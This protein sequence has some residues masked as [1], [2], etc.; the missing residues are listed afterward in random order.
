MRR[1]TRCMVCRTSKSCP[2][3]SPRTG[4]LGRACSTTSNEGPRSPNTWDSNPRECTW[5]S[6]SRNTRLIAR[7]KMI[8][9]F[10]SRCSWRRMAQRGQL[11]LQMCSTNRHLRVACW[12]LWQ[13]T[14]LTRIRVCT[15]STL[16]TNIRQVTFTEEAQLSRMI[17]LPQRQGIMGYITPPYSYEWSS[18][19]ST[20]LRTV[21]RCW[22]AT[23]RITMESLLIHT[24]QSCNRPA[25]L[26]FFA[27][28]PRLCYWW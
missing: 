18:W 10:R 4:T 1:A 24:I 9:R 27:V 19:Y 12:M 16:T 11:W 6:L 23:F 13:T 17:K 25:L 8:E 5:P 26:S 21:Q 28:Y 14:R 20:I 7:V 22:K 3:T 2:A 15:T